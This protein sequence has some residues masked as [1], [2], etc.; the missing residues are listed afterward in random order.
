M[1]AL[2]NGEMGPAYFTNLVPP[3]SLMDSKFHLT[4][5]WCPGVVQEDSKGKF[6]H[7]FFQ[8]VQKREV[9]EPC[10]CVHAGAKCGKKSCPVPHFSGEA[11]EIKEDGHQK[12]GIDVR[13]PAM[14]CTVQHLVWGMPGAK[15]SVF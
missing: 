5:H 10:E 8:K 13:F 15:P 9:Y 1:E 7:L 2:H 3:R 12:L 6:S 4:H 14:P 11:D